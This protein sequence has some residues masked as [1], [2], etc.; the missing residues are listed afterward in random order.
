LGGTKVADTTDVFF[1]SG[2]SSELVG[3]YVTSSAD[4]GDTLFYFMGQDGQQLTVLVHAGA[5]IVVQRSDLV[6]LGYG[7][8]S[9][10]WF[11][12]GGA[13]GGDPCTAWYWPAQL[14]IDGNSITAS[15][16]P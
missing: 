6:A 9:Y 16:C 7:Q 15:G 5:D 3:L 2:A 1:T 13:A 10:E 11:G 14:V 4:C 12:G 8:F